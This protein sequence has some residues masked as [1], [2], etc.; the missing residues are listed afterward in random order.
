MTDQLIVDNDIMVSMRDGVRL[1]ADVFRP[2]TGGPFPVLVQRYPYS[3]RDGIMAMFGRQI[4]QQGYAV[5]V[6]SCRGRFG[7]EGDFYP[8]H[9]DIGDSYD[10]VEWAGVQPWS[11]GKVG[12]YGV[13]YS[14]MT[15]WTAAIAQT[16]HLVCI[17]PSVCTWDWTAGG[18]YFSPGVLTLGLALVWSAQMTAY[19]A[20]KRNK[21]A[22]LEQF[23]E[24]ARIMDEGG[25]GDPDA[26]THLMELQRD[27]SRDLFHQWPLRDLEAL[28]D[29]AP[30][31][32][33]WCDHEDPRDDYWHQISGPAHAGEIDL[34]ILHITGWHDY[35]TKGSLDAFETLAGRVDQRLIVGPWNHNGSPTRADADP[36][37]W[38]FFDFSPG[39]PVMRFFDHH[40][41]GEYPGYADESPV[42]L[43]IMAE[44]VWRDEQEWPLART[45]WTSYYLA[46]DQRLTIE[47]PDIESPDEYVHDPLDPVP[48]SIASGGTFGDPVDFSAI[49]RRPDVLIFDTDALA[50]DTEITGPVRLELWASSTAPST[51][52]IANLIEVLA[53]GSYEPLCNGVVRTQGRGT[54]PELVEIDLVATA[55][56][57][58][59]GHRLRLQVSSSQFPTFE[60]NPSTGLRIT[61]TS[62]T[63]SATQRVFHDSTHL[64]R[65][66]LPIVPH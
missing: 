43:Y 9:P 21:P 53:D 51:D 34:P 1:R 36:S 52:F 61:H 4:A 2:A 45:Q 31:F 37:A 25:L 16:P 33:D 49:G 55:V 39:S 50:T 54:E 29:L 17:A 13:S 48:G 18:W 42:R 3:T 40:L 20:E 23:A 14:G 65:L 57:V 28:Q 26:M 44:N 22:P 56:L 60:L 15:Q 10:T 63:Q 6:Q 5:V 64:S 41:K 59:R 35:F 8:F 38:M 12:M 66:I 11:T 62:A 32:R 24:V 7:S 47:A 46:G 58:R 27:G 19:E 30:W